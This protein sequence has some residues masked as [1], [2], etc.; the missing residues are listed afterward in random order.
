MSVAYLLLP[1]RVGKWHVVVHAG[2]DHG[3]HIIEYDVDVKEGDIATLSHTPLYSEYG[4]MITGV[5]IIFGVFGLV[6]GLRARRAR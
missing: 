1:D 6:Y 5:A 2:S 4:A 3:E